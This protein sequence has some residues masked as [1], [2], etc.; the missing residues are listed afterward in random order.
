MKKEI[1][2]I[3]M[4]GVL[5]DLEFS[6]NDYKKKSHYNELYEEHPDLIPDVFLDPPPIKGSIDAIGKLNKSGKY[7]MYI[8]TA[9]PWGNPDANTHKRL[10]IERYFGD[11]FKK[12]IIISHNKNLLMG[13]YLIDDRTAN[14]ASEFTGELLHFGKDYKTGEI[15]EYPN[16]ESILKKLL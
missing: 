12:K 14:G 7:D 1:L 8:A 9:A 5:V 3:D 2:L 13:D 16:W 15:N 6:I 11:L 10:W 4:D